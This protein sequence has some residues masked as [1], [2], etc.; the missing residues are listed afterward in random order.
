MR[1]IDADALLEELKNTYVP[2]SVKLIDLITNAPAIEQW[3]ELS[4]AEIFE[5]CPDI[6]HDLLEEA[7]YRGARAVEAKLKEL[8]T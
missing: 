6:D 2:V 1:L 3:V 4:D 8:K 5:L 7:F